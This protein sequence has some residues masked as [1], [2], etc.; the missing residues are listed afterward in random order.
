MA[1][2]DP[3]LGTTISPWQPAQPLCYRPLYLK[4]PFISSSLIVITIHRHHGLIKATQHKPH[5]PLEFF[6][7]ASNEDTATD[8]WELQLA[9]Q[10]SADAIIQPQLLKSHNVRFSPLDL[11]SD[12]LVA[13][14]KPLSDAELDGLLYCPTPYYPH[15]AEIY[16]KS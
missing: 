3:C 15:E 9:L 13:S 5:V 2:G 1:G 10:D 12:T 4:G 6:I 7:A 16:Q 14:F 8:L 11:T